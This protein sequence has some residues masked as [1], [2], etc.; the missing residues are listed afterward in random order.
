MI[1][2]WA[3]VVF[4]TVIPKATVAVYALEIYKRQASYLYKFG[5]LVGPSSVDDS[6]RIQPYKLPTRRDGA[7][8][9]RE[10]AGRVGSG[11]L[12]GFVGGGAE[13][14][15]LMAGETEVHE[16]FFVQE[17]DHLLQN[18]Y[19]P[20]VVFDQVIVCPED[21]SDPVLYCKRGN[22]CFNRIDS[23]WRS[24]SYGSPCGCGLDL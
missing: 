22:V 1:L 9:G 13:A 20:Q 2:E 3:I 24:V 7:E 18:P 10:P 19:P 14:V 17:P 12:A 5:R 11:G 16:P 4:K 23:V 6:N 21:G 8:G 15:F